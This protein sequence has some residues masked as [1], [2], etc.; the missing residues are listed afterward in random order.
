MGCFGLGRNSKEPEGFQRVWD[1]GCFG[2]GRNSK[3]PKG[4]PVFPDTVTGR[5]YC[6][7]SSTVTRSLPP[8]PT[9]GDRRSD[10]SETNRRNRRTRMSPNSA[11][12]AQVRAGRPQAT[13]L[14]PGQRVPRRV[15]AALSDRTTTSSSRNASADADAGDVAPSNRS[16]V[17]TRQ[18]R[19]ITGANQARLQEC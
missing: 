18:T 6:R 4:F 9:V 7:T 16:P 1:L 17:D 10:S 14:E 13:S 15:R 3:E 19:W 2:L 12:S 5:C 8:P 11:A